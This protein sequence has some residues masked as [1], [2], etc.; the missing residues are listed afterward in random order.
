MTCLYR[1]LELDP[2][3]WRYHFNLGCC[4]LSCQNVIRAII[5]LKAAIHSHKQ[6]GEIWM[7]LGVALTYVCDIGNA[8]QAFRNSLKLKPDTRSHLYYG[9]RPIKAI[10]MSMF[11][12]CAL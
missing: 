1:G 8:Q 10:F 11:S 2:F 4:F 7:W 9:N 12:D 5:H 6:D 3:D